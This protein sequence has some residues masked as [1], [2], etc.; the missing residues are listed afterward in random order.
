MAMLGSIGQAGQNEQ[1]RIGII[2]GAVF[3]IG[4]RNYVVRTSWHVA[5][6]T[7]LGSRGKRFLNGRGRQLGI[8][9]FCNASGSQ[10]SGA[11]GGRPVPAKFSA[12]IPSIVSAV[13]WIMIVL[14]RMEESPCSRR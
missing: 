4:G 2:A 5:I 8:T 1:G 10:R 3:R 13:P 12:V 6:V 7:G 11:C 9:R 14:P